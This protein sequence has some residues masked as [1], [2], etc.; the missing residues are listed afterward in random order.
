MDDKA[1]TDALGLESAYGYHV[2]VAP[3]LPFTVPVQDRPAVPWYPCIETNQSYTGCLGEACPLEVCWTGGPSVS[4][5]AALRRRFHP[6]DAEY[7]PGAL[8]LRCRHVQEITI[9]AIDARRGLIHL[10]MLH[11]G[12]Q[13]WLHPISTAAFV[14]RRIPTHEDTDLAQCPD[15]EP[16]AQPLPAVERQRLHVNERA[17]ARRAGNAAQEERELG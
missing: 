8:C 12:R 3:R 10:P 9:A 4:Y 13:R 17:R 7:A 11:C 2:E 15:F 6:T 1:I 14:R 5:A 16:A